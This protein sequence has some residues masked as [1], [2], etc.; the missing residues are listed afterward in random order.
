MPRQMSLFESPQEPRSLT[1][2][3][4]T[5]QLKEVV[6]SDFSD[7]WV[8]GEISNF[9][10]PA[11][12][13]CYFT[14]K[15]DRA[16][17]RAVVWKS[18]AERLKFELE[19]G[20]EVVCSGGLEVYAPRGQYQIVIRQI[21]PKGMGALEL[22]LR[23]LRER[24]AAEGLF[25]PERKRPLVRF[26]RRIAVVTSPTGAAIRDFLQVLARRW[27]GVDV[28]IIP[29]RVQGEGASQEIAAAIARV[30]AL[31]LAIDTLV[32]TRGGGSIEDLWSFN[33]EPTV[34][35]IAASRIPVVSAVGHE[36]D[37]TLADLAADV[38]A[39]TPSEAAE[40]VAPAADELQQLL[41]TRE[42]HLLSHWRRRVQLARSIL[43]ALATRRVLRRPLDRLHEL[44]RRLDE[45]GQQATRA[46]VA[47]AGRRRERIA[48][49]AGRLEA[50]SP[51]SV[52][53]RGYSVTTHED[54]RV[55]RHAA[56]L[57]QGQRI[58]TRF[59]TGIT[60]SRVE[61]TG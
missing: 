29:V 47:L 14:L 5:E 34:R 38:R 57:A 56:E 61:E 23:R 2:S 10:R 58:V 11:S 9:A 51:L 54:G 4:L 16:Q 12:G 59:A 21:M 19:D 33:E 52:L 32:V 53:C 26:P 40:R 45:L 43:N 28:L 50:L 49:L 55:V 7:V 39:L 36:I 30:N 6:E 20:L 24:L 15:D 3:Q 17:L 41:A 1:V 44:S 60:T 42:R 13:H 37:V 48:S 35:A 31:P 22:A 46:T 18:A 25:A 8:T 27:R